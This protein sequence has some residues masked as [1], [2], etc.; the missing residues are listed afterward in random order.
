MRLASQSMNDHEVANAPRAQGK[1]MHMQ[2]GEGQ[3]QSGFLSGN[4][5]LPAHGM[6]HVA[7]SEQSLN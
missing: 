6:E 1:V 5:G 7:T 3:G 4:E 2:S